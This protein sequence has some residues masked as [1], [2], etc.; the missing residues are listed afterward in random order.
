MAK[1]MDEQRGRVE[2]QPNSQYQHHSAPPRHSWEHYGIT[3][4]RYRQLT[5]YIQSGRYD[6]LVSLA[7]YTANE[8]IAEWVLLSVKENKSYDALKVKWELK[9]ME[10]IPYCRT[11]FYGIR[12]YFFS[13]F[14]KKMKEI[15]K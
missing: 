14:N 4:E 1:A 11:D 13:V 2:Q 3:K 9:E 8:T 10:R 7:A 5:E 15:G 12:R 6:P